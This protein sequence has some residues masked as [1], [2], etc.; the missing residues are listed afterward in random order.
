MNYY[1]EER[2]RWAE[3]SAEALALA[4]TQARKKAAKAMPES[5]DNFEFRQ[6]WWDDALE[7]HVA[8]V[9]GQVSLEAERAF[10]ERSGLVS[11]LVELGIG[12]AATAAASAV[13]E[14]FSS[15]GDTVGERFSDVVEAGTVA[16]WDSDRVSKELGL[17]GEGG[18][19]S[20]G[21][22]EGMGV[23]ASV[24][25]SNGAAEEV[26]GMTGAAGTATWNCAF[27]NSRESH[28]QADGQTVPIGQPFTIG[29]SEC[30]Y[31][32]DPSLPDEELINCNCWL[33]YEVEEPVADE[34]ELS[35]Q[36]GTAE[37]TATQMSRLSSFFADYVPGGNTDGIIVTLEPIAIQ[38]VQIAQ[39]GGLPP[40]ELHITLVSLGTTA[41]DVDRM[42]VNSVLATI[43]ATLPAASGKIAGL[44][45]FDS[46]EAMTLALIDSPGIGHLRD[47]IVE[48]MQEAGIA[49]DTTHDFIPHMTL[50]YTALDG[51][52][53]VG[54]PLD[55]Y[56][57]RLRWG[58]EVLSFDLTGVPE[59]PIDLGVPSP[60]EPTT[61]EEDAAMPFAVQPD[62]PECAGDPNGS[63]GVVNTETGELTSCW[64]DE[65]SAQAE[66]DALMAADVTLP[67]LEGAPADPLLAPLVAAGR[68]ATFNGG[69]VTECSD[70][71]LALELARRLAEKASD[72]VETGGKVVNEVRLQGEAMVEVAT[73]LADL[74]S[75]IQAAAD[76]AA[77]A[78]PEGYLEEE[79]SEE[80]IVPVVAE[81]PAVAVASTDGAT[82][83]GEVVDITP[84]LGEFDGAAFDWEGVLT[85]EG[86]LSGDG[87][88]ILEESLT[89]RTLPLPLMFQKVNAPGHDGS[90]AAG[91]IME[92]ERVGNEIIGRGRYDSGEA[93][94]EAKRMIDEGTLRGVSV[95]VDSVVVMFTDATTG[96]EVGFEDYLFGDASNVVETLVEGRIMGA[97]I[98]PFPAFEQAYIES[99]SAGSDEAL[100]ASG[101]LG[102]VWRISMPSTQFVNAGQPP[103]ALVASASGDHLRLAAPVEPPAEWFSLK[104][105]DEVEPFEVHPDG[106]VYGLVAKFGTCHIG[107]TSHCVDVPRNGDFRTFY[108][109]KKHIVTSD[110]RKVSVGPIIMGTDHADTRW[111]DPQR[112]IDHY[113]HTG[114]AVADVALYVN[115]FGIVAAGCLRPDADP[116]QVRRLRA[117]DISPDWR[118]IDNDLKLVALLAV[119]TSG[120]PVEALVAG[121]GRVETGPLVTRG[122]FDSVS[123]RPRALVA[124]GALTKPRA[125]SGRM[126]TRIDEMVERLEAMSAELEV[127]RTAER[128][129][130]LLEAQI[131]LATVPGCTDC[132]ELTLASLAAKV[133][134]IE[135]GLRAERV[136]R[137]LVAMGAAFNEQGEDGKF[138]PGDGGEGGG[139]GSTG[140]SSPVTSAGASIAESAS[141]LRAID[142]RMLVGG[143]PGAMLIVDKLSEKN[144]DGDSAKADSAK[145]ELTAAITERVGA[146]ES[147]I[148][149]ALRDSNVEGYGP[150]DP[151]VLGALSSALMEANVSVT[152]G[153]DQLAAVDLTLG[154]P[155]QPEVSVNA[156]DGQ[157]LVTG[158][159]NGY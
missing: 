104:P 103:V 31:P 57:L 70:E 133:E 38:K 2:N 10:A 9:V 153:E 139:A 59:A 72:T 42:G 29:G 141:G 143:S 142:E 11:S 105:M 150:R 140:G 30:S 135:Q 19:L 158:A 100:V 6:G 40:N 137:A 68:R 50:G 73:V 56:E 52:A 152:W 28:Q 16:E 17:D 71:E 41:D 159:K 83:A 155:G 127:L 67:V 99:I 34:A 111:A 62:H 18:P 146:A 87:R 15:Y 97:T 53:L 156:A 129:R 37:W 13:L 154:L 74:E 81:V 21:L 36:V 75:T 27:F 26:L 47:S 24:M 78:A 115:D 151:T 77:V 98:T 3:M 69:P 85:V 88:A 51:S 124:A 147:N 43:A 33:T 8:P 65:I 96:L 66:V 76:A 84:V 20:E 134:G 130:R 86:V 123:G 128:R 110:G 102:D 157:F 94:Q 89:W 5:Y 131:R 145:A 113:A 58:T 7:E 54:T 122:V 35:T 138:Q 116:L 107:F 63:F 14:K 60:L 112:A 120:F 149:T 49:V 48:A 22:A 144:F 109:P 90:M 25:A 106:R 125:D 132:E 32:G 44:G 80:D 93:G 121:G 126:V 45:W 136:K 91:Q 46:P 61:S 39:P 12:L 64:P 118:E 4:L 101:A 95:D 108:S 148:E 1:E 79:D 55:F 119:N 92:I 114:S 117:S 82:F 23:T